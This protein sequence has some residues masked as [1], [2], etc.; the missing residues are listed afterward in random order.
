MCLLPREPIKSLSLTLAL[1]RGLQR[2][3][4]RK[5]SVSEFSGVGLAE[6]RFLRCTYAGYFFLS[7]TSL[8]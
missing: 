3:A 2:Q 5:I 4:L 1:R 6:S 7:D 8:F